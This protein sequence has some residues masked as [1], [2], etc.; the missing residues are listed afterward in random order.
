MASVVIV[1][2][3]HSGIRTAAAL[4]KH[5]WSGNIDIFGNEGEIPY[6]R[7]PLSKA[8]LLGT[9]SVEACRFF[10]ADWYENNNIALHPGEPVVDINRAKCEVVLTQGKTVSYNTLILATGSSP[11]PL[12]LPGAELE[13][14][15]PLR[16][17]SHARAVAACLQAGKRIVIIGAGIIG[18]E[19]AAAAITKGCSVQVLERGPQAMSRSLPSLVSAALITE[20]M[21]KGVRF[22]FNTQVAQLEGEVSVDSIRLTTGEILPCDV[23]I[24]GLGVTP[25]TGLASKAGLPVDNGIRTNIH[26][27][28]PDP[29]IFACGDVCC[30]DSERYGQ[31]LRT[32]NWRNAEEQADVVARNVLDQQV[33]FDAVPW[34]WSNQ[35]DFTL[36][37]TG[38]PAA[39]VEIDERPVGNSRLFYSYNKH[40]LCGVSGLGSVRDI[41]SPIREY[42]ETRAAY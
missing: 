27:Q 3:G 37:V 8:V 22:Y 42:R 34:F 32:E 24:Y 25:N 12:S 10:P 9:K 30:Y 14:V 39:G 1:G 16:T 31:P 29:H 7:P 20:H 17:L 18:L 28:T 23:V 13:N 19:V 40:G 26:L 21:K 36:Q 11:N 15:W 2:A 33:P 38:L 35:Y 5:G 6:D 41:A 4:R